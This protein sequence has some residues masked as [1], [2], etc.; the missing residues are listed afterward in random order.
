MDT[1]IVIF[2]KAPVPGN[3]KTRLIPALGAEGAAQLAAQM[4]AATLAEV[5]GAAPAKFELCVTPNAADAAWT[6]HLPRNVAISEQGPG[7]LG[8]RMA[9]AA[10]RVLRGGE[11]VILIG[12]DCPGLDSARLRATAA[13]L[14]SH[15]A[16]M[17]PAQD[18]GYVLLGLSRFDPSLFNGIE[19]SSDT[20]GAL[21]RARIESL[22]W[23]LLI[24]ETLRDIDE[25]ADLETTGGRF[26]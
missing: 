9:A 16:V 21:T 14:E 22:G 15:D 10:E 19:W 3:A 25:P 12:T 13:A 26:C 7:D 20:V 4:L 18:G 23:R 1:R 11:R 24:G 5:K 8:A 2:A 17:H 6:G